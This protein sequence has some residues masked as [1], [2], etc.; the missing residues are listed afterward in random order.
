M[1]HARSAHSGGH[2][3]W[4]R[5][6]ARVTQFQYTRSQALLKHKTTHTITGNRNKICVQPQTDT[7]RL[8]SPKLIFG[9]RAIY[10]SG[11]TVLTD[12]RNTLVLLRYGRDANAAHA[13]INNGSDIPGDWWWVHVFSCHPH[14]ITKLYGYIVIARVP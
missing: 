7:I 12:F 8:V 5:R 13:H 2:C 4:R 6:C 3:V 9:G 1:R 10:A 11:T 14:S